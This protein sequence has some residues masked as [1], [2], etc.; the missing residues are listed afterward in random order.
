MPF[1][2]N[3]TDGTSL[4]TVQDGSV[5]NTSTSITLIGKNFPTYGQYLNQDLVSMLENSA[6]ST[7][8][9]PALNGQLWYDSINKNLNFYRL[10]SL[11]SSWQKLATTV[12]SATAPLDPRL[13]DLWW[14]TANS[15]LK[16]YNSTNT[17][18]PWT[19]VG[20]QTTNNGQLNVSGG[21]FTL[22]VGGNTVLTVDNY[23]SLNLARNPCVFGYNHTAGTTLQTTGLTYF[24][25]WTPYV[26][27]DAGNNFN[28]S[29]GI[30]TVTTAGVYQ[31][32]AHATALN[33][34]TNLGDGTCHLQWQLDGSDSKINAVTKFASTTALHSQ[35]VCAGMIYAPVGST[36]QLVYATASD[37]SIDYQ[38][39]SYSIRLVQ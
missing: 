16:I 3:H 29:T 10:G 32:Y 17:T 14:D 15:Q 2:I 7:A 34:T 27:Y 25:A 36:I 11:Q 6:N 20:P 30:F 35:L 23:G 21:S 39:A 22:Q 31:L 8:P 33:S 1:Y 26:N 4:V 37:A 19:V 5:D 24:N 13:G 28:S 38:N 12:E 9:S 18:N